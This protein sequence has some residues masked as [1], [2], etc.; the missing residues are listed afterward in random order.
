MGLAVVPALIPDIPRIYD[1]YFEAFKHD[2]MGQLIVDILFPQGVDEEFKKAHAAATLAYWNTSDSQFTFKCIDLDNGEIVGMGLADLVVKP[3]EKREN[4][5]VQWLEGEERAR[6]ERI[7]NPLWEA[8]DDLVGGTPHICNF[9]SCLVCSM[10]I[11]T[12]GHRYSTPP[13]TITTFFE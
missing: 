1:I 7:L 2:E 11:T 4:P 8:R 12:D 10:C 5:G 9:N 3:L 6:A 13:Y